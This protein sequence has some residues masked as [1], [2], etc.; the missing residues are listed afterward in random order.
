MLL[1][2][3]LIDSHD[4]GGISGGT[5]ERSSLSGIVH[6]LSAGSH[7]FRVLMTRPFITSTNTPIQ[8]LDNAMVGQV[9]A[10]PVP[11]AVWLFGTA[12]IG[13]AG[14]SRKRKVA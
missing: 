12:L 5:T 13:I 7:E 9:S 8:F 14:V 11:A 3:V 10:V 1:N 6:G 2:N 4:F